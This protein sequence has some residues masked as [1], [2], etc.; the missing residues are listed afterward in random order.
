MH[1]WTDGWNGAWEQPSPTSEAPLGD[2]PTCSLRSG[3]SNL[4]P[5]V[6]QLTT[7]H[8]D[9]HPAVDSLRP[10][11]S[12]QSHHEIGR[13]IQAVDRL[14]SSTIRRSS[15][16]T[17]T[18]ARVLVMK[19]IGTPNEVA[20]F[21]GVQVPGGGPAR[22]F[23]DCVWGHRADPQPH[24]GGWA[25]PTRRS[26]PGGRIALAPGGVRQGMAVSWP[27]AT[28][29]PFSGRNL[30]SHHRRGADQL[31]GIQQPDP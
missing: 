19:P 7:G 8:K 1:P 31:E 4:T 22:G 20:M 28:V 30:P 14:A 26:G 16:S 9:V 3:P 27:A 11:R 29:H 18:M 10:I 15:T 21:N 24:G 2:S 12:W 23:Y 5:A 17:G 25:W 13:A 6:D